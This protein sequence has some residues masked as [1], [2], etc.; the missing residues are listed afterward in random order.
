M[1]GKL[2]SDI[3]SRLEE[4][5]R[6]SEPALNSAPVKW[7]SKQLVSKNKDLPFGSAYD[8]DAISAYFKQ[9]PLT[10][11]ARSL[12]VLNCI[13]RIGW[14]WTLDEKLQRTPIGIGSRRSKFLKDVVSTMGPVFVKVAQTLSTRPDIV[15]EE[16]AEALGDLQDQMPVFDSKVAYTTISEELEWDG[17]ISPT[18][19]YTS[20]C[21]DPVAML[22]DPRC[23]TLFRELSPVPVSA[24]SLGQVYRGT[25]HEG[26][27]IAVKVQRPGMLEIV[28]RD[29]W[30]LRTF[31][32]WWEVTFDS[33]TLTAAI[34]DEAGEGLL[35][36]LNYYKEA[37]NMLEFQDKHRFMNFVKVPRPISKYST[38]RVLTTEWVFGRTLQGLAPTD[39]ITMAQMGIESSCAQLL[40]TG[41][42][43]ADPHEGNMLFGDD[44]NLYFLDFGLISRMDLRHQEGMAMCILHLLS[45]KWDLL[46]D[47]FVTMGVVTPPYSQ[48]EYNPPKGQKEGWRTISEDELRQAFVISLQNA[49]KGNDNYVSEKQGFGDLFADLTAMAYNYRFT[50]PPYYVLIMRSFVT[51]EGVAKR[52]DPLFNMYEAALPYAVYRTLSPQTRNGEQALR[53]VLLNENNEFRFEELSAMIADASEG[54]KNTQ[55]AEEE[56]TSSQEE[57]ATSTASTSTEAGTDDNTVTPNSEFAKQDPF[58][59]ILKIITQV[60]TRREGKP[61]R[62]ILWD[63]NSVSIAAFLMSPQGR[64]MV[65][66]GLRKAVEE[67]WAQRMGVKVE[68]EAKVEES[69]MTGVMVTSGGQFAGEWRQRKVTEALARHHIKT[70]AL[71]SGISGK[72]KF[73]RMCAIVA[74]ISF[75]VV[76]K[77]LKVWVQTKL[78]FGGKAV[79]SSEEH[80]TSTS[81]AQMAPSPA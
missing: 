76:F 52:A 60:F 59:R 80:N 56:S 5:L 16:A 72:L 23:E 58:T 61:L 73:A 13:A 6:K 40:M 64:D 55:I 50:V 62:R 20:D 11:A 79:K 38:M 7:R 19:T 34:A 21:A 53:E 51:L 30:V 31:L 33:N 78:G 18:D 37:E 54:A 45:G 75:Q 9:Q 29:L 74:A 68:K 8:F 28:A 81:T 32:A 3:N 66:P 43:H 42:L 14:V 36:E 15:G 67:F 41:C 71:A 39:Q 26:Q 12:E 10:I 17:P 63:T 57:V 27:D 69:S 22:G 24:A 77:M 46:F 35:A 4:A 49:S 65:M 1:S 25:T 44:G 2:D 47:D 48:W 70:L